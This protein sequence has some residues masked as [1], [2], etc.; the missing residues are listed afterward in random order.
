LQSESPALHV[1]EHVLPLHVADAA[2]VRLHLSP[3]ALQLLVV[4]SCVQVPLHTVSRQLHTPLLQSGLG[5]E[6]GAQFAP[7]VPQDVGD[8]AE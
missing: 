5:C 3:Q 4:F 7:F 6:Q 8:C 1:Y 2:L